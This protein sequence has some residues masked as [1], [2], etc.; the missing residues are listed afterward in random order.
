MR[1]WQGEIDHRGRT[2][3]NDFQRYTGVGENTIEMIEAITNGE[4]VPVN[5]TETYDNGVKVVPTYLSN[6]VSVDSDNYKE[7]LIDT[8]YYTEEELG[9]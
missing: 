2:D 5:D 4:E 6:P 1:R 8:D 9:I 3:P 7:E